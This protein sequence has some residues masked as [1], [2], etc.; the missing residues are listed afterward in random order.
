MKMKISIKKK[1]VENFVRTEYYII[2]LCSSRHNPVSCNYFKSER[3]L[4]SLFR[5]NLGTYKVGRILLV[6]SL[7]QMSLF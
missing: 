7:L 6:T 1:H 4:E 2:S 3:N 5:E